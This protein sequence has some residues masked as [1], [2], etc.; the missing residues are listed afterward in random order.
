MADA[1]S[2]SGHHAATLAR[3]TEHFRRDDQVQALL[4]TGSLAHG[5]AR[6]GSD[7]DVAIVVSGEE[8]R[9]RAAEGALNFYD[10]GL[11]TYDGGYVD[12]KFVDLDFMRKVAA[13]GSEPARYA[14]KDTRVLFSRID[15]LDD[16][17]QSVTRYPTEH[18]DAKLARFAA[19]LEAWHWYVH[20][21]VDADNRYLLQLACSKLALFG[22]R[23]ILAH[24]ELLYPFHK[25]LPRVVQGATSKPADFDR[26]LDDLTAAPSATSASAFYDTVKH[27]QDW[28]TQGV[29]W[30]MQFMRDTELNWMSGHTP[31]DDL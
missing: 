23:L 16:L 4:L 15:G 3:A 22:C 26:R 2:L 6:P 31:V 12:G 7:V 17:L 5:F 29:V 13:G 19:Q 14:F 18:K 10:A 30:S 20:Q 9:R 28:P 25:W 1:P 11:S 8:Y 21:A 27:F 24:N